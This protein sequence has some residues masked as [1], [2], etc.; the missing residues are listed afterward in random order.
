MKFGVEIFCAY[1]DYPKKICELFY[2]KIIFMFRELNTIANNKYSNY[3][4]D[5]EE[6][7]FADFVEKDYISVFDDGL[8][9]EMKNNFQR[10]I[11]KIRKTKPTK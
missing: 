7:S 1:K 10:D 2:N 3:N 5:E 11:Y 6:S 9:K 4:I 8:I